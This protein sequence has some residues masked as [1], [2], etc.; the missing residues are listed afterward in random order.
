METSQPFWQ[1]APLLESHPRGNSLPYPQ[2][3]SLLYSL[4]P[5]SLILPPLSVKS[6]ALPFGAFTVTGLFLPRWRVCIHPYW[7]SYGSCWPFKVPLNGWS[8]LK[9]QT[10]STWK[11]V[12]PENLTK[13]CS[14]PSSRS[15][16]KVTNRTDPR[17]EAGILHSLY[18]YECAWDKQAESSDWVLCPSIEFSV[19]PEYN[20]PH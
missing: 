8:A 6:L 14:I 5:L 2:H 7:I 12:S 17:T 10:D 18:A 11:L 1:P 3:E 4:C 15:V 13:V 16:V 9:L 19:H 20:V